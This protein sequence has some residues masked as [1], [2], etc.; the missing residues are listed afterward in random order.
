MTTIDLAPK[1]VEGPWV[2]VPGLLLHE[3]REF[4]PTASKSADDCLFLYNR[5]EGRSSQRLKVKGDSYL[6]WP[7]VLFRTLGLD[8]I[9]CI[10][11]NFVL[12]VAS[13]PN[14][15]P[16]PLSADF[17]TDSGS[18]FNLEQTSFEED[19]MYLTLR[20]RNRP[21]LRSNSDQQQASSLPST[22]LTSRKAFSQGDNEFDMIRSD[23]SHHW[24]LCNYPRN[25]Q[26]HATLQERFTICP[27]FVHV[28]LWRE[29]DCGWCRAHLGKG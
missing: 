29:R 3:K 14:R 22:P 24:V 23:Q 19:D 18:S 2:C 12:G 26:R 16:G 17:K 1:R 25:H 7:R 10:M 15:S 27:G 11:A 5:T 20:S 9:E 28:D 6:E 8:V 4:S 21:S 13:G